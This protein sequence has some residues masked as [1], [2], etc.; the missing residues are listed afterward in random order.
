MTSTG[1]DV[2]RDREV[3]AVHWLLVA[4]A[5][6][7]AGVH[8]VMG[9]L[10]DRT[11]FVILG[12]LFLAGLAVFFTRYFRPVLYLLG[13]IYV[14]ALTAVWVLAGTPFFVV[15]FLDALVQ[16]ALFG[17]F[18]YLFVVEYPDDR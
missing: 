14:A 15:G 16:V 7:T 11:Q 8:V 3:R 6:L 12:V 10:T 9:V 2:E 1:A 17:L 4:L 13:A 5:V 18:L